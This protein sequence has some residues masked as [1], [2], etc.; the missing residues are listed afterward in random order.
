MPRL[1]RP[2]STRFQI[3]YS[4]Y[5]LGLVTRGMII[6]LIIQTIRLA[7]SGPDATGRRWLDALEAL[8]A[9]RGLTG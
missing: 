3:L 5:R 4:T 7:P 2:Q 1:D 9:E 6:P 8:L